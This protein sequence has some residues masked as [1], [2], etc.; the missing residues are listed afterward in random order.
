MKAARPSLAPLAPLTVSLVAGILLADAVPLSL[1][2]WQVLVAAVLMAS[3]AGRWPMLRSGA[4][5]L[6]F[7]VLG[8]MVGHG[9]QEE[10]RE[11]KVETV[12]VSEPAVRPKT[13]AAG[14]QQLRGRALYW[15]HRLLERYQAAGVDDD[16]Y[17]VLAAMTLGDK[18][19]LSDN[20]RD[21]YSV[22]GASHVLALSGLHLG[23]IYMLLTSLFGGRRRFWLLQAVVILGIWTFTFL[24]G[25]SVST[26]RAATMISLFALFSVGGRRRSS[27]NML[28][29][30]AMLMLLVDSSQLYDVS[31]QL[32]F[33][34]VLSILLLKPSMDRLISPV[35]L[36]EHQW[37]HRLWDMLTVSL[38]A[39]VG[40]APLIAYYFHRFSTYF[41]LTNLVALPLVTL[42]L[43][44][45]PL[46]LMTAWG[47][48]AWLLASLVALLNT[49]LSVVARLPMASIDGLHPSVLHVCMVYLI[50]VCFCLILKRLQLR[51]EIIV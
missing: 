32:S 49:L 28:C 8:M 39:Q 37:L 30:T 46:F 16:G 2:L 10:G 24:T 4:L 9:R 17:A 36:Q 47:W 7:V 1:P 14:L 25:L 22:T 34:A 3:L 31:F 21:T 48:A 41:L 13:I 33:A 45:A 43:W 19:A 18:S 35:Y 29:F 42:I 38:A 44:G 5:C 6:G 20:V 26:V 50:I 12:A 51:R 27:V 11:P 40:V 23:I 15:R